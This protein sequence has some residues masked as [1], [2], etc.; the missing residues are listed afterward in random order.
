M[1]GARRAV[2]TSRFRP[3]SLAAAVV[4]VMVFGACDDQVKRVPIFKTMSWQSS[5]EAFEP[6]SALRIP[7]AGTMPIDGL[8]TYDLLAA[9]AALSSPIAGTAAELARGAMLFGQFCSPC[10]GP[11]GAGDGSVVGPNR[12]PDIPLLDLRTELTRSYS[13]G[14]LWGMITNGRGLMPS[15]RRIPQR[16]RWYIVAHV[17]R[18]QADAAA[19]ELATPGSDVNAGADSA[20]GGP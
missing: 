4:A 18:L 2:T 10:H 1:D 7:V 12:I 14:Y 15:Y 16:D 11:A 19:A 9:D 8:R 17:R 13:D 20:G 5:V 3:A 6:D